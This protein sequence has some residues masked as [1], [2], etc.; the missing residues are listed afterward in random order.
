MIHR[1]LKYGLLLLAGFCLSQTALAARK[2]NR[3]ATE[4]AKRLIGKKGA[5]RLLLF[6]NPELNLSGKETFVISDRNGRPVIEGSSLS[7]LTSGLNWY[8]NHCAGVNLSWNQLQTELS[9][10]QLPAPKQTIRKES[11]V[12]L[13]Y[14]LN[15]CT[16]SYSMAFWTWERWEK[17]IDWMALHGINMPLMAVGTDVVWYHVLQDLNYSEKEINDFIAGPGFQ[18]WWMMNNLQGWGGPNPAWWYQRQE[19]L[20]RKILKRMRQLGMT[21]VLPGYSGMVPSN[22]TEKTGWKVSDPGQWCGFQRPAFLLPTDEHFQEMAALYYKHL[23]RLMGTSRY[24]SMDPFHEGG[25]VKGVDL[26]AAYRAIHEAMRRARP[27]GVWVIQSW[28]ENPRKECLQTIPKGELIVLDLFADG[29]PKWKTGYDGQDMI[30]CMLHN[31]GGRIGLHGRLER[32]VRDFYEVQKRFPQT[33]KGIGATPEGIETNPMLYDVLFELPWRPTAT[34]KEVLHEYVAARY[35]L[36]PVQ[37]T[38]HPEAEAAWKTVVQAWDLLRTS[39]YDCQT[40]QQGTTEPVFCARPALTVKSVSSWST[41][42]ISHNPEQVRQAVRLMLQAAPVLSQQTNYQY[43]LTDMMRQVLSD[44]ANLLLP[45]IKQAYEQKDRV[46]FGQKY[47][48]FLKMLTDQDRLL[49]TQPG[50]MLGTWTHMA[51][52]VADE[53][54]GTQEKDRNWMEWNARTLITVWGTREAANS[55]GLHDYSNREWSGLLR[56]FHYARWKEFFECLENGQPTPD[57][58]QWF[59]REEAWTRNFSLRYSAQPT[60]NSTAVVQELAKEYL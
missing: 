23:K 8:L 22:I 21:P 55:G 24:Y 42:K 29:V 44:S 35:G 39:V 57:A 47:R 17:E 34:G 52:R 30:Y 27:D 14:Y 26:S 1:I 2:T 40:A 4:M 54:K 53:G 60:G 18:A 3:A 28:N 45:Q 25:S 31:F 56:D 58:D 13:R 19:K 16:F 11:S 6:T 32:T 49:G 59:D 20:T 15:Y 10:E 48:L 7:A 36:L 33:L 51:R 41:A 43:D 50:F 9:P 12:P 5:Q 46:R 37:R 38:G